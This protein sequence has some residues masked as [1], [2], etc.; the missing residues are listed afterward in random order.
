MIA[1]DIDG[2]IANTPPWFEK[3]IE[4]K[5]GEKL[6]FTE[7][8]TYRFGLNVSDADCLDCVTNALSKYHDSIVPYNIYDIKEILTKLNMYQ[9]RVTF[10]TARENIAEVR[11]LTYSW[12]NKHFPIL[13]YKIV[14]LGEGVCKKEWMVENGFNCIVEDR[15]RTANRIDIE[16]GNTY[17]VNREWNIGRETL[18]HVIRVDDV[19][20]ALVL[21]FNR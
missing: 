5:I 19:C 18:P 17:L 10:L 7:P 6:K 13:N 12:F 9:G 3:E 14:F 8:R 21:Y 2:V 1:I 11:A 4:E 15:L 16:Y 20:E